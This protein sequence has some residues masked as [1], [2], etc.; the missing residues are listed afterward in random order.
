MRHGAARRIVVCLLGIMLGL[1]MGLSAVAANGVMVEMAIAVDAEV[2]GGD[3]CTGCSDHDAAESANCLS[4]CSSSVFAVPAPT[5][6]TSTVEP[7]KSFFCDTR[8]LH[9]AAFSPDPHPPRSTSLL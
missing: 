7:I 6:A 4:L 1:G 8:A 2:S 3:G 5:P 9:G